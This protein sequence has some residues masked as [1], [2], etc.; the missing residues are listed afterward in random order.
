MFDIKPTT[1]STQLP[2]HVPIVF[3]PKAFERTPKIHAD[4]LALGHRRPLGYQ[5]KL[6]EYYLIQ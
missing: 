2:E 5:I 1:Y 3:R 4:T 6:L